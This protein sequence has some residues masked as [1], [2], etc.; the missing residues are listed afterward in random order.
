LLGIYVRFFRRT[1]IGLKHEEES[2][3]GEKIRG[4]AMMAREK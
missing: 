3:E 4:K 2:L 1:D